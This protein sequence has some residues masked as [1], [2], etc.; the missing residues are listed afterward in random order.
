MVRRLMEEVRGFKE[1]V[2]REGEKRDR[3]NRELRE[4]LRKEREE[5]RKE[6]EKWKR[7]KMEGEER[8]KKMEERLE[9]WEKREEE[10]LGAPI[11]EPVVDG[12]IGNLAAERSC[13]R[14]ACE[15]GIRIVGGLRSDCGGRRRDS[16]RRRGTAAEPRKARQSWE[17]P[18]VGGPPS[19]CPCGSRKDSAYSCADL[20]RGERAVERAYERVG[21]RASEEGTL[22]LSVRSCW[23]D[24]EDCP[25]CR[26]HWR[27]QGPFVPGLGNVPREVRL[28]RDHGLPKRSPKKPPEAARVRRRASPKTEGLSPFWRRGSVTWQLGAPITELVVDGKIGNLAAERPCERSAREF[29]IRIAGGLRGNCSERRRDS[30]KQWGSRTTRGSL[31]GPASGEAS[32]PMSL[33]KQEE[34]GLFLRGSRGERAVE[35]ANKRTS[36][37]ERVD[38]RGEEGP[39]IDARDDGARRAEGR[40]RVS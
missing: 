37:K 34:F 40:R 6:W 24:T 14:G 12:K 17:G 35:R 38:E 7:E 25:F 18:R 4:E 16:A 26:D 31:G 19:R 11:T 29:G 3:E 15:F 22:L 33:R 10:R 9:R 2:K 1:E 21:E 27:S 39:A 20:D 5:R 23:D 13:E 36:E 28:T 8:I 32:D 30:A